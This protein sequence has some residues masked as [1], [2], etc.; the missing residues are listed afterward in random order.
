MSRLA[1]KFKLL[2][3]PRLDLRTLLLSVSTEK[4]E[5]EATSHT[6]PT[7]FLLLTPPTRGLESRWVN[8]SWS[9]GVV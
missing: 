5:V 7:P 2:L 6:S 4:P 9:H 3:D 8:C 1:T